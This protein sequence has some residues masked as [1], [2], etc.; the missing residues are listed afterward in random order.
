MDG[1]YERK[2]DLMRDEISMHIERAAICRA[3][4]RKI[5]DMNVQYAI[6]RY[7]DALQAESMGC[8]ATAREA[9]AKTEI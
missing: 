1:F 9:L 7:G 6:D 2:V 8:V 4:L 5:I 3:A